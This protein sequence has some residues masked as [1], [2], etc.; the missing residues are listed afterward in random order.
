M[1]RKYRQ[2]TSQQRAEIAAYMVEH[3]DL[4]VK[5]V[6]GQFGVHPSRIYRIVNDFLEVKT[7]YLL[8]A[9]EKPTE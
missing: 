4:M 2:L 1:G 9:T 3:P 7:V 6:A 5:Q 8:K